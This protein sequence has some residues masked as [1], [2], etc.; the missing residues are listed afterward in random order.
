MQRPNLA[1][2]KCGAAKPGNEEER[3][4][5]QSTNKYKD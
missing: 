1:D 3:D 5:K 2:L 4:L